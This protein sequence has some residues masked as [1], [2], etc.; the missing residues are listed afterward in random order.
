MLWLRSLTRIPRTA[1]P[2]KRWRQPQPTAGSNVHPKP[3]RFPPAS[4]WLGCRRAAEPTRSKGSS[5]RTHRSRPAER[6]HSRGPSRVARPSAAWPRP[7]RSRQ[8]RSPARPRP[9]GGILGPTEGFGRRTCVAPTRSSATR[10]RTATAPNS[11]FLKHSTI[12]SD[13]ERV[14]RLRQEAAPH[15]RRRRRR[16]KTTS[17]DVSVVRRGRRPG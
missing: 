13:H 7:R 12:S 15:H 14:R 6:S 9:L 4:K 16:P 1:A 10:G 2:A 11:V 17:T 3:T 8:G 5:P